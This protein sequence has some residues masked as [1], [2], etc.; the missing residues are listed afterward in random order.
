MGTIP[1]SFNHSASSRSSASIMTLLSSIDRTLSTIH[2]E[3]MYSGGNVHGTRGS[4][5]S[6]TKSQVDRNGC[7]R[8]AWVVTLVGLYTSRPSRRGKIVASMCIAFGSLTVSSSKVWPA[9]KDYLDLPC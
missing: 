2:G 4:N 9:G 3:V 6:A 7:S 1:K 8:N 5:G